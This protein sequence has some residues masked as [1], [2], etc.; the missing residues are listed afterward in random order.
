M[1]ALVGAFPDGKLRPRGSSRSSTRT[2]GP[3]SPDPVTFNPLLQPL[4]P[5]HP[6]LAQA[7]K[8]ARLGL[9]PPSPSP[10]SQSQGKDFPTYPSSRKSSLI[11]PFLS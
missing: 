6:R 5:S 9:S 11:T 3:L 2:W 7:S 1:E 8:Q 4:W 10:P